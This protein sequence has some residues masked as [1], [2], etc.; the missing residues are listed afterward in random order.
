MEPFVLRA[1]RPV[2]RLGIQTGDRIVWEPEDSHFPTICRDVPNTG[3]VLFAWES[4]ALVAVTPCPQ[5]ADLRAAVGL[6]HPSRGRA[7]H[8]VRPAHLHLIR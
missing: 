7:L 8:A 6:P 1:V 2:P 3:A 4:G 5:P